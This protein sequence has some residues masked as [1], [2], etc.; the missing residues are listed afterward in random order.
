[1]NKITI[2]GNLGRDPEMRFTPSGQAVTKFSVASTRQYK[3]SSGEQVKETTWFSVEAWGKLAEI[4]N[5][6][7]KKGA[8]VYVEGRIKPDKSTGSPHV[9]EKKDG[10]FGASFE[11]A[12]TEVQFLDSKSEKQ[13]SSSP[14]EPAAPDV[15]DEA[16]LY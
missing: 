6:Y 11:V 1:M 16:N 12:A 13:E 10:T 5:Q 3:A 8:K 15:G 7:L 14:F 4:C 2:I 9:Y